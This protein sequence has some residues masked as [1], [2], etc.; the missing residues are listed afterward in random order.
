M[1]HIVVTQHL[2]SMK[3]NLKPDVI[4]DCNSVG[5]HVT[6]NEQQDSIVN[7]FVASLTG[8]ARL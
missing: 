2:G 4:G 6:C 5:A 7:L 1:L 3:L 8:V